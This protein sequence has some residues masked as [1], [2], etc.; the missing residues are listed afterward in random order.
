[1]FPQLSASQQRTVAEEILAFAASTSVG[2]EQVEKDS[3][4]AAQLAV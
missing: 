1:M 4:T 3:V 2:R